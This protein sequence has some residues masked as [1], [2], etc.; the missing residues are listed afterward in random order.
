MKRF[1]SITSLIIVAIAATACG[2]AQVELYDDIE[3]QQTAFV[4]QLEGGTDNQAKF[5]SIE[6]LQKLQVAAK[7]IPT[8]TR[9]RKTGRMPWDFEWVKTVKVITVDR[10]P[11][12]REWTEK[13]STGTNSKNEAIAVES[14]D[15]IGFGVGVNITAS[16]EEENAAR[17]LYYYAGKP[18]N[19]IIDTNIRS[20]VQ[21]NVS[22]AFGTRVLED[23]KSSKGEIFTTCNE[24]ATEYFAE[25][26][27][28]IRSLGYSEGLVYE[29]PEIQ[30]AINE[31]YVAEMNIQKQDNERLAQEKTNAKDLSIAVTEREIAEEFAKAAEAKA[32]LVELE[33]KQNEALAKLTAAQKWNGVLPSGIVP[34]GSQFLF[35]LD[36]AQ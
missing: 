20:F 32:K 29:N 30:A 31:N 26:G 3:P 5:Q 10:T 18:L 25:M 36:A 7:R 16:V 6:H 27:I 2:P 13:E 24:E 14:S 33:V 28:T 12:T 9:K 19:E 8:P 17:F 4:V 15:S 23:C 35:G 11:V 1:L 34:Q 22:K 21:A